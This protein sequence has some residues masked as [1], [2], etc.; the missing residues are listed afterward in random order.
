MGILPVQWTG[1]ADSQ[2]QE[3]L[4]PSLGMDGTDYNVAV[5]IFFIP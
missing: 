4:L 3:G 1:D 2:G 5:S